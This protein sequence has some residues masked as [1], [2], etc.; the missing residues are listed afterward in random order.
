MR[1]KNS[2]IVFVVPL[3]CKMDRI[4]ISQRINIEPN[5]WILLRDGLVYFVHFHKRPLE[6]IAVSEGRVRIVERAVRPSIWN[7]NIS[8]DDL[9]FV[10]TVFLAALLGASQLLI[11]YYKAG[12]AAVCLTFAAVLI[13]GYARTMKRR[14]RGLCRTKLSVDI[15]RRAYPIAFD[16]IE[17]EEPAFEECL[18][19]LKP[20]RERFN[21]RP[22]P[23]GVVVRLNASVRDHVRLAIA[24][25]LLIW[26]GH[27]GFAHSG[28]DTILEDTIIAF[29]AILIVHMLI[30]ITH[31]M[32]TPRPLRAAR[33]A[34]L[35]GDVEATRL[36]LDH[37]M[38]EEPKHRYGNF[39]M[40]AFALIEGDIDRA[41]E[42]RATLYGKWP[43]GPLTEFLFFLTGKI[44]SPRDFQ[45][46]A[47]YAM[48][49]G[50][51]EQQGL[52]EALP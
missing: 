15:G 23:S 52:Q 28:P 45:L 49:A 26:F 3:W 31:A 38:A 34:M 42:C 25:F 16:R 36:L 24:V 47:D 29:G 4:M 37:F 12:I 7:M 13:Y 18:D 43:I 46:L 6:I 40:A 27:H 5:R 30:A 44:S 9:I 33:D 19:R 10:T 1:R 39:L 14:R 51:A 48:N 50:K 21:V 32:A 20:H 8:W 35:S 41:A 11:I 17:G 22:G 2:F